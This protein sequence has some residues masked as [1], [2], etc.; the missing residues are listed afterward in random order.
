MASKPDDVLN[1]V[2]IP[3]R[4]TF[5]AISNAFV[6]VDSF[7]LLSG[8]LVGYLTLKKLGKKG[9]GYRDVLMMYL[10]R[11]IR[12]TPTLALVILFWTNVGSMLPYV[13]GVA[14]GNLI[15]L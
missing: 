15:N 2:K 6:S 4:F 13:L 9:I 3:H 1:T 14:F 11:Y 12:L 8:F 10:H 5:L 7:F